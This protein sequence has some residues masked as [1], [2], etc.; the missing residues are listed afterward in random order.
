MPSDAIG[1]ILRTQQE[2]ISQARRSKGHNPLLLND[3]KARKAQLIQNLIQIKDLN[4]LSDILAVGLQHRQK[5]QEII[6]ATIK[7]IAKLKKK[8]AERTERKKKLQAIDQAR[9]QSEPYKSLES[10]Y[11]LTWGG[12]KQKNAMQQYE[13]MKVKELTKIYE[14]VEKSSPSRQP[15]RMVKD[16][17]LT[18]L[19]T[20]ITMKQAKK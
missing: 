19:R 3:P 17:L 12:S 16:D 20:L 10:F 2:K 6:G 4:I 7:K 8:E 13:Q 18:Y 11:S 9:K 14:I 5:P 15:H 1:K